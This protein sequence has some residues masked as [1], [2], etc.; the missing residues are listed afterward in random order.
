MTIV[1]N[2]FSSPKDILPIALQLVGSLALAK[3]CTCAHEHFRKM[4]YRSLLG[5]WA[6]K[7]TLPQENRK[8]AEARILQNK[9]LP[10]L[11][12]PDARALE[13]QGLGLTKFP[14]S[15]AL[16]NIAPDVVVLDARN[17]RFKTPP[18]LTKFTRLKV[19]NLENACTNC[20]PDLSHLTKLSTVNLSLNGLKEFPPIPRTTQPCFLNLQYNKIEEIPDAIFTLAKNYTLDL[21]YNPLSQEAARK[22][23]QYKD[24]DLGP[25]ILINCLVKDLSNLYFK[26]IPH[27]DHFPKTKFP[28]ILDLSN[29]QI[30]EVPEEILRLLPSNYLLDLRGNPLSK[31]TRKRLSG[32]LK[33]NAEG[34]RILF[35]NKFASFKWGENVSLFEFCKAGEAQADRCN[36]STHPSRSTSFTQEETTPSP[37]PR[38]NSL[39]AKF[40]QFLGTLFRFFN[41]S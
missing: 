20:V 22:I 14:P 37:N 8:E 36:H 15:R 4:S 33:S 17:N 5:D 23:L 16:T 12:E 13:L 25:T 2:S 10:F 26:N 21:R 3:I 38:E 1:N 30:K 31:E 19:L 29:N 34:P 35:S 7:E 11:V 32:Y 24:L 40:F 39:K 28:C 41:W 18:S 6:S 9:Q 27:R